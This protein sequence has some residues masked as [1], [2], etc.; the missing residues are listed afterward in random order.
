MSL[1]Q[2]L[3][4]PMQA[5]RALRMRIADCGSGNESLDPSIPQSAIRN[6]MSGGWEFSSICWILPLI[7]RHKHSSGLCRSVAG[8]ILALHG[9][10]IR[11]PSESTRP[12][13]SNERIQIAQDDCIA[14]CIA[15]PAPVVRLIA[16]D[17]H[18][19][20]YG[21][22][23]HCACVDCHG[24]RRQFVVW[25]PDHIWC[26]IDRGDQR[27]RAVRRQLEVIEL[28]V[29]EEVVDLHLHTQTD[30]R[31]CVGGK[32]RGKMRHGDLQGIARVCDEDRFKD[33]IRQVTDTYSQILAGGVESTE[34]VSI[35]HVPM[36]SRR[37][38][39][40][41]VLV[42]P[43]K[44]RPILEL[45]SQLVPVC[46]GESD[47]QPGRKL[48]AVEPVFEVERGSASIQRKAVRR[49]SPGSIAGIQWS[50]D[51]RP[52]GV[53]GFEASISDLVAS[54]CRDQYITATTR[55]RKWRGGAAIRATEG[56]Q[57][58]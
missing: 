35:S 47:R 23:A 51:E 57:A 5:E 36:E 3:A 20:A 16:R 11:P 9:D 10:R 15:I 13:G 28:G 49:N 24:Y 18:D 19:L 44:L 46:R 26:G 48:C 25:R 30:S 1:T 41:N 42:H 38:P 7:V 21:W 12:F 56:S 31:V 54:R 39:Q 6:S 45:E 58:R 4:R 17:R 14:A 53:V 8:C 29:E 27:S 37:W 22:A 34:V 33:R 40:S 50:F 52:P 2:C 32:V 43:V 55:G